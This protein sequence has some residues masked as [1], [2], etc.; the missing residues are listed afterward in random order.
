MSDPIHV[1]TSIESESHHSGDSVGAD[2]SG[3]SGGVEPSAKL[4]RHVQTLDINY[5]CLLSRL[6]YRMPELRSS[7]TG[8]LI[9][10]RSRPRKAPMS[11]VEDMP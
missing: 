11:S 10:P 5:Y 3:F 1:E 7:R 8:N 6:I 9:H 2:P 4:V